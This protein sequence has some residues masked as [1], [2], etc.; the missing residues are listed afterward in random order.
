MDSFI[1]FL[2]N[3]MDFVKYNVTFSKRSVIIYF[4][5]LF[6]IDMMGLLYA[7]IRQKV[8]IEHFRTHIK[9]GFLKTNLVKVGV[10]II[11]CTLYNPPLGYA[12][13]GLL[14]Y[15]IYLLQ[16]WYQLLFCKQ[17]KT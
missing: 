10:I 15:I 6:L 7:Q 13:L 11:T 16:F 14:L 1:D 8:H 5:L 9:H 17:A 3:A 4:L 2:T 12:P